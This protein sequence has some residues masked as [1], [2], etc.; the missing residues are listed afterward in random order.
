MASLMDQLMDENA[1][2]LANQYAKG[3]KQSQ[4]YAAPAPS[5]RPM[6]QMPAGSPY[7]FAQN[8]PQW[9]QQAARLNEPSSTGYEGAAG[10]QISGAALAQQP[11]PGYQG[12]NMRQLLG[13]AMS[14]QPEPGFSGPVARQLSALAAAQQPEPG[15]SGAAGALIPQRIGAV[16]GTQQMG[17]VNLNVIRGLNQYAGNIGSAMQQA[18]EYANKF[19]GGDLSKVRARTYRDDEGQTWND[20]Y[21]KGLLG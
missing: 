9:V 8:I 3:Y 17:P 15:Y 12:P 1:K 13:A 18:Q 10:R 14:Q 5:A 19:A 21:V 16:Q 4:P 7:A 2:R 11:E 20:Y 6:T